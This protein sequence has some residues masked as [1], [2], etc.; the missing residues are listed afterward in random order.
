LQRREQAVHESAHRPGGERNPVLVPGQ[1]PLTQDMVSQFGDFLEWA[2]DLRA[3]GGLTV[4]QRQALRELLMNSWK[5]RD[6]SWKA[7]FGG[8][9]QKWHDL[10]RLSDGERAQ[11]QEKLQPALVA[12]LRSTPNPLNRWLLGI[13]DK[14]QNQP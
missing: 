2:L 6:D 5:K 9:L 13:A 8:H 14:E 7:D 12:Q 1:T 10:V 4:A 11:V 3:S